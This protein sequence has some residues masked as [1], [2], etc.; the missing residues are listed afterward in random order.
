MIFQLISNVCCI[1]VLRLLNK[2]VGTVLVFLICSSIAYSKNFDLISGEES[3]AQSP[4]NFYKQDS[5][6]SFRSPKGYAPSLIK[7]FGAQPTAPFRFKAKQWAIT[8]GV[9]GIT[10]FLIEN[11]GDIDNWAKTQK[12]HYDWI[13]NSSPII[14]EFGGNYGIG[15]ACAFG[16]LSAAFNNEKGIQTSLLATQAMITSGI[17][18]QLIKQVAGRE[19]PRASYNQSRREGGYWYGPFAQYDQELANKKPGSSF[20][21]F[22]SGHTATAFSIATV[23]AIQYKNS[24]LIPALSYTA[25]SL[26]GISR[27]T[28]HQHWAS[29]V[30]CGAV[31]GYLCGK[32]VTGRFVKTHPKLPDMHSLR[33]RQKTEFSFSQ[34]GSQ[35]GFVIKW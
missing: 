23:F 17:W 33:N 16:L 27:L 21:A 20:D 14:T 12:N 1:K 19:R 4:S 15:S 5:V 11:D 22:A 28:E 13:N 18:V 35:V 25:A 34:H 30:F 31:L 32:Q 7:N 2:P 24:I 10:L 9:I 6:F 29:D 26:V 8:G 3:S